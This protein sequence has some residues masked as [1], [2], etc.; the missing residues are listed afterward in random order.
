[1]LDKRLRSSMLYQRVLRPTLKSLVPGLAARGATTWTLPIPDRMSGGDG[2]QSAAAIWERASKVRWYHT[3]DLGH[4]VATPGFVDRRS[5]T[6]RYGLP[7]S[8]VGM[9][10]LDVG[11]YD[12]F[13]AFEMERRGAQE[14]IALDLDSPLDL[15]VPRLQRRALESNPTMLEA[16]GVGQIGSGF[17][18]AHEILGSRAKRATVDVYKLTEDSLGL[19]D[20]VF[21]SEVLLHL[22]DAQTALENIY[23]VTRDYVVIAEPF[24]PELERLNRPVSEFV[25]TEVVGIWWKHSISALKKMLN[26]AGFTRVEE[27]ARLSVDNRVG[28]FWVVVLKAYRAG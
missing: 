19:F 12:G 5:V 18:L 23:S 1:M 25:G 10:C 26:V 20:V 13:W 7:A 24:E 2:S 14:V 9:R 28:Q 11:T 15:D 4:G 27:V 21:V 8:L 16:L 3:I 17:K 22:R 6:D